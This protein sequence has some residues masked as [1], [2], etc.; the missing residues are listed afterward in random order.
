MEALVGIVAEPDKVSQALD[1]LVEGGIPAEQVSVL[2]SY[3]IPAFGLSAFTCNPV[4]VL[5]ARGGTWKGEPFACLSG[6]PYFYTAL[7][8]LFVLGPLVSAALDA[9]GDGV[10]PALLS[11]ILQLRFSECDARLC[12]AGLTNGCAA[13]ALGDAVRAPRNLDLAAIGR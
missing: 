8:P 6:A 2:L 10:S 1:R 4:A 9:T 13:I 5:G 7:G 12:Y 11:T 3:G